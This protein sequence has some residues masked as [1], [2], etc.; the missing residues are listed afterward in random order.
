MCSWLIVSKAL[1]RSKNTA[2]DTFLFTSIDLILCSILTNRSSV[3]LPGRKPNCVSLYFCSFSRNHV[4]LVLT[5]FSA[6]LPT[7][8]RSDMGR[9][10]VGSDK[11]FPGLR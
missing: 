10:D 2:T 6:T 5:I 8:D 7:H 9:Y 11:S 4:S 1:L 3:V